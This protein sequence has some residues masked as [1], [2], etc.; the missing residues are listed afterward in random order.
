MARFH[1]GTVLDRVPTARYF[2]GASHLELKLVGT[3]RAAT[4]RRMRAGLPSGAT[5]AVQLPAAFARG[6][7]GALRHE[8]PA[9]E[10]DLFAALKALAPRFAVL[11][12]GVELTPSPRDRE[13][14]EAFAARVRALEGPTLAWQAGGP[15]EPEQAAALARRIGVVPVFD[16]LDPQFFAGGSEVAYARI[17]AIGVHARLS[18]GTLAK[19]AETLLEVGA[20]DTYVAIEAAEGV[21][22]ARRLAMILAGEVG[23]TDGE[24]E[25]AEREGD[26]EDDEE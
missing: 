18:D 7:R 26:G 9:V 6:T 24:D 4:A 12:T 2:E 5:L 25:D 14:L 13:A 8:D 10:S 17:R 15:W 1:V 3:P 11:V 20:A 16:P 23:A 21:R 22:R 19:V